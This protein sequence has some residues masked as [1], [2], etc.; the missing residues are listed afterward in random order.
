MRQMWKSKSELTEV[1]GISVLKNHVPGT[2]PR[3]KSV[4]LGNSENLYKSQEKDFNTQIIMSSKREAQYENYNK[5][6]SQF[7]KIFGQRPSPVGEIKQY[8][9]VGF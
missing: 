3:Q 9:T 4:R 5:S 6:V 7:I 2:K 1:W 8:Y